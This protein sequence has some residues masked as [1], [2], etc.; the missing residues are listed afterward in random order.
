M[1]MT[2]GLPTFKQPVLVLDDIIYLPP[3]NRPPSRIFWYGPGGRAYSTKEL[4]DAGA[5]VMIMDLWERYWLRSMVKV[6]PNA[7]I[8]EIKRAYQRLLGSV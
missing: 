6:E 7:T 8:G 3:Y 4:L 1:L 5:R 2:E